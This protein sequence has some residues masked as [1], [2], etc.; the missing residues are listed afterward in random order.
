MTSWRLSKFYYPFLIF[1]SLIL[2]L[3][4]YSG[5]IIKED[6]TGRIVIG[7]VWLLLSVGWISKYI[8]SKKA[9]PS[10]NSV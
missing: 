5:I 7:N 6:P 2:S 4:F 3:I 1:V 10:K 8:Y 9:E